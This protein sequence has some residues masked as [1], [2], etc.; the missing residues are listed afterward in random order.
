[1]S[2]YKI[3]VPGAADIAIDV[4]GLIH[5]ARTKQIKGDTPILEIATGVTF[6]AKQ[7]P[8]VFSDKEWLTAT[9]LSFFL[10]GLGVDR[11]YT[12]YTGLG[13]AKLLTLGGCGIW[14]LIDL[15]Q[16][17]MRNIPDAQGRPLA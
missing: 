4:N 9:L 7:I 17:L 15:I 16:F 3:Q 11:F 1:M 10:G 13:V 5:A 6:Q 2:Q 14:S 12:G 8:G